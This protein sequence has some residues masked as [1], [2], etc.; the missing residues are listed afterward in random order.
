M[1]NNLAVNP[2]IGSPPLPPNLVANRKPPPGFTFNATG[3]LIPISPTNAGVNPLVGNIPGPNV[4][5]LTGG[6]PL[7]TVPLAGPVTIDNAT[8]RPIE[9]L[10]TAP[11]TGLIGAEQALVGGATGATGALLEGFD[12]GA[13]A[14]QTGGERAG[15]ALDEAGNVIQTGTQ[16]ARED[17]LTGAAT[18]RELISGGTTGAVGA[19][20]E[21]GGA[22]QNVLTG[23]GVTAESLLNRGVSALDTGKEEGLAFLNQAFNQAVDP[24][25]GFIDPG[26][27][28][29]ILQ[30]ALTGAMGPEAQRAALENFATDPGTLASAKEAE[31]ALLRNASR[32]GGVGGG[33]VRKDLVRLA[34]SEAQKNFN[35]RIDQLG[36]QASLGFTAAQTAGGLR[37]EQGVTGL[38]LIGRTAE[39]TAGLRERGALIETD[40]AGLSAQIEQATGRDI[41]S[42][43]QTGA[44]TQADI[45][46]SATNTLANLSQ[47]GGFAQADVE[48]KRAMIEQATGQD[49]ATLANTTGINIADVMDRLGSR[50][51]DVRTQAGRD[52]AAAI[53]QSSAQLADLQATQGAGI[54]D[55]VG[56]QIGNISNLLLQEGLLDSGS[57]QQLATL[58]GNLAV[59]EGTT[60]ANIA[61]NIG[62]IEA[63]GVLGQNKAV[64]SGISGLI[65]LLGEREK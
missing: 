26:Q 65:E 7:T 40:L 31:R 62:N 38:N 12:V 61:A 54:S 14:I 5:Q 20:T 51:A 48:T 16:V 43:L 29:Q 15:V 36:R 56:T 17:V 42:A 30:A 44:I 53:A 25:T 37:A 1:A 28:A 49:L 2:L 23:A 24:I 47:T 11:T 21:A 10:P 59:G 3:Q 13:G 41:S 34:V 57:A 6:Q 4:E 45:E 35:T 55:I 33:N 19:V 63:A 22:A 39:S 46:Q 27:Q 64:Q 58:L 9:A 8:G 52:I 60:A 18:G 32:L 50:S